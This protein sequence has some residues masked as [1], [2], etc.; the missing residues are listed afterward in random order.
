[1]PFISYSQNREDV[2]LHRVF[3]GLRSGFYI[4]V[5]ANDP[6]IASVT[7]AFSELGWRGINVE[8]V[9]SVFERLREDRP[10]DINLNLGVSNCSKTVAFFE[11]RSL[12]TLSTFSE[13]QARH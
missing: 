12:T 13:A 8:P 9:P 3:A 6:V 11:C 7:K 2:V 4:D 5:G 10:L 1:M